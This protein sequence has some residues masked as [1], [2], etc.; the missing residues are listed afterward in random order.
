MTIGGVFLINST[1]EAVFRK[2]IVELAAAQIARV[3]KVSRN[4]V[5]K[6]IQALVKDGHLKV[7]EK[8]GNL[9]IYKAG[10]IPISFVTPSPKR[11]RR[12]S[13]EGPLYP[14]TAR[15]HD[16]TAYYVVQG[17]PTNLKF[18]EHKAFGRNPYGQYILKAP[19]GHR[20]F[21][22]VL[23]KG[24]KETLLHVKYFPGVKGGKLTIELYEEPAEASTEHYET[25]TANLKDRFRAMGAWW[26]GR[27][28]AAHVSEPEVN[29]NFSYA[30]I[31][32]VKDPAYEEMAR[33]RIK[34][35]DGSAEIDASAGTPETEYLTAEAHTAYVYGYSL[36]REYSAEAARLSKEVE[37][38]KAGGVLSKAE[39][40][41]WAAQM[42]LN[43][44]IVD[45]LK[46]Q[47]KRQEDTPKVQDA[48]DTDTEPE[49]GDY[50][51]Q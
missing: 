40:E 49:N 20:Y 16:L 36:M 30:T 44:V 11:S 18:M 19:E 9:I 37:A 41:A 31:P 28:G 7:K 47:A 50:M 26:Q 35:P 27:V 13:L 24:V 29:Y 4:T 6:H 34:A 32:H 10:P 25:L 38:L 12:G 2:A 48:P 33:A 43:Q 39:E 46:R 21:S 42:R 3:L 17:R 22:I 1:R 51:Y 8:R 5:S 14:A 23:V 15:P 45:E